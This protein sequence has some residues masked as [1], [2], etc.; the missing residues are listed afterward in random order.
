MR[1]SPALS[2]GSVS[3]RTAFIN[4][5]QIIEEEFKKA[6][7]TVSKTENSL[8]EL[9]HKTQQELLH[10][11]QE[12]ENLKKLL[13]QTMESHRHEKFS[14]YYNMGCAY[15]LAGEYKKAEYWFLN[16]LALNPDDPYVHFNLGILYDDNLGNKKKARY[17]YQR[18]L[19]LAPEDKDAARV[20]EWLA[21]L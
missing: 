3:N 19:Q 2:D 5:N 4:I 17:H 7:G 8:A 11:R 16:A 20:R 21:S 15:Q 18:F 9:L 10:A 6:T 1:V 13:Q 14:L 12:I